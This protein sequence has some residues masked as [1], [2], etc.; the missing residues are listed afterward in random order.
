[1]YWGYWFVLT[2][3]R[4]SV[5][6]TAIVQS[7]T[8]HNPGFIWSPLTM[9][10]SVQ[11]SRIVNS[12]SKYMWGRRWN[13]KDVKQV[14]L[15]VVGNESGWTEFERKWASGYSWS[16]RWRWMAA[17]ECSTWLVLCAAVESHLSVMWLS[18]YTALLVFSFCSSVLSVHLS[19]M[20]GLVISK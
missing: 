15:V 2:S 1:M 20:A 17:G 12:Q 9:C 16:W 8:Q 4:L 11:L 13:M 3:A 6:W 18:R 7:V 14:C 19:H 5:L 10:K